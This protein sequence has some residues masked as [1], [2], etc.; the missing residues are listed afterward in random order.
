[1]N[2]FERYSRFRDFHQFRPEQAVAF[3]RH[4]A[5]QISARTGDKLSKATLHSTLNAQRNFFFWLA[6]QPGYRSRFSYSDADYFNLSAKETSI[7]KARREA[8]V[9]TF[10]QIMHV[11][12]SMPF[13]SSIEQRNRAIIAFILLT[14][15]RDRALASLRLKHLHLE[16][17]CVVQGAREVQTKFSKTST[18]YFFPVEVEVASIVKDWVRHLK[19]DLLWSLDD[20]LFPATRVARS[21]QIANLRPGVWT[22][23][24]V[25]TAAPIRKIFKEAFVG[26]GLPY[27][28]PHS[29]RKTLVQLGERL[30]R[31]PE[32]FKAWSQNL[33][34]ENVLTTFSSCGEVTGLRQAELLRAL[35]T[36]VRQETTALDQIEQILRSTGRTAE[37]AR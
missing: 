7:A 17:A 1:M 33:A 9:P 19:I 3:K 36:P 4:L 6:G 29:F 27:F 16:H 25:N 8:Q 31:T 14:G 26:A 32:E 24:S 22:G 5:E 12:Q 30:C 18:I 15:I 21:A 34:H 2:R 10:D 11:L 13:G 28:A 20:P 35:G 37:F 23:D